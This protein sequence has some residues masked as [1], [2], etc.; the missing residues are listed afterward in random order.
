MLIEFLVVLRCDFTPRWP[1][2]IPEKA[3]P[4]PPSLP[5]AGQPDFLS[6]QDL[7]SR[8]DSTDRVGAQELVGMTIE[9]WTFTIMADPYGVMGTRANSA[10][11]TS[12]A[13]SFP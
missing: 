12:P 5:S 8:G 2:S 6:W 13:P 7:P 3:Q 4:L 11:A 1:K 10:I 9:V